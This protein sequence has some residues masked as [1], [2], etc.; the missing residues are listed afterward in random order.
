MYK[1]YFNL[2]LKKIRSLP[3]QTT[4]IDQVAH[5]CFGYRHLLILSYTSPDTI[6]M[7]GREARSDLISQDLLRGTDILA[8]NLDQ[9]MTPADRI[10]N[11][12]YLLHTL[13]F[14]FDQEHMQVARNT[15]QE[16][17]HADQPLSTDT[18]DICK[19]LCYNYYF[20]LDED[21]RQRVESVL[22]RWVAEQSGSGAWK[23]LNLNDILERLEIMV[24]YSDMVDQKPYENPIRKAFRYCVRHPQITAETLF[25]TV[26]AQ[27]GLFTQYTDLMEQI[28]QNVLQGKLSANATKGTGNTQAIPI[29]PDDP[30]LLAIQ[31]HVLAL[32]LLNTVGKS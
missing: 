19:I 16:V 20:C 8:R 28:L 13:T 6:S 23:D 31:F 7:F 24:M 30:L 15:V 9:D 10:R 14:Q 22:N 4:T 5:I 17:L 29:D 2:L 26:T 27:M 25:L 3:L 32:Y 12:V 21:S 1:S 18:P 11:I